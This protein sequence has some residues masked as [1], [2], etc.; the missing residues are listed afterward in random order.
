MVGFVEPGTLLHTTR[1]ARAAIRAARITESVLIAASTFGLILACA[2]V[3]SGMTIGAQDLIVAIVCAAFAAA[4][5]WLPNRL[6]EYSVAER[7]DNRLHFD[8]AYLTAWEFESGR[9]AAS[10][11]ARLLAS[12]VSARTGTAHAVRAVLPHSAPWIAAPFLAGALLALALDDVRTTRS[13]SSAVT[14]TQ[15]LAGSLFD[16]RSQATRDGSLESEE[17]EKLAALASE[18]LELA[19]QASAQSGLEDAELARRAADLAQELE[20][21]AADSPASSV[22]R[23]Q[24]EDSQVLADQARMAVAGD[25]SSA[26]IEQNPASVAGSEVASGGEPGTMSGS[27]TGDVTADTSSRDRTTRRDSEDAPNSAGVFARGR[28]WPARHDSLVAS[29][30]EAQRER[31]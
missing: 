24:L 17:L 9:L 3:S 13:G 6:E 27:P 22:L 26:T 25:A 12:R 10:P 11:L 30:A 18:A 16:L 29:W 8:G 15:S 20:R 21:L 31:H 14:T 2:V 19:S 1:A 4:S 28:W 5:W 23:R 7:L